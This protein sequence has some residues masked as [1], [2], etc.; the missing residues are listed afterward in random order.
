[1]NHRRRF[2]MMLMKASLYWLQNVTIH[3][4]RIAFCVNISLFCNVKNPYI[5]IYLIS[6]TVSLNIWQLICPHE[7]IMR[8]LVGNTLSRSWIYSSDSFDS[9]ARFL[10]GIL[11][12][13]WRE[14]QE[15]VSQVGPMATLWPRGNPEI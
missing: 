14:N 9:D 6:K 8:F 3:N 10:L 1:M 5:K 2:L 13:F 12:I 15:R 11:A 7:A 4:V